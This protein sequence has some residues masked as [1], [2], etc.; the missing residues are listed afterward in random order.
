ML[1]YQLLGRI[2]LLRTASLQLSNF[3]VVRGTVGESSKSGPATSQINTRALPGY[4]HHEACAER[5]RC[6]PQLFKFKSMG[7]GSSEPL[8]N[9]V[10]A[11]SPLRLVST[12]VEVAAGSGINSI[13][14]SQAI[15]VVHDL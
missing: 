5:T 10:S 14:K 1:S 2:L 8:R 3:G 15:L 13:P 6:T 9:I 12:I 4:Y 11:S 7:R